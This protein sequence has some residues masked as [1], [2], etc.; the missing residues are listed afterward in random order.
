MRL[1][2]CRHTHIYT[3][4]HTH[5]LTHAC[6]LSEVSAF[7][8]APLTVP[9]GPCCTE[10]ARYSMPDTEGTECMEYAQ[11]VVCT[12]YRGTLASAHAACAGYGAAP[13]WRRSRRRHCQAGHAIRC[14]QL[15][16]QICMH[17]HMHTDMRT[18]MCT[19]MCI[20]PCTGTG[21][22]KFIDMCASA[23][24]SIHMPIHVHACAHTC[25]NTCSCTSVH[26]PLPDAVP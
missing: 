6:T 18:D 4:V 2:A 25:Q 1:C 5:V 23:C 10:C 8:A 20:R 16:S 24:M 11:R 26:M 21:A 9:P 12:G 17:R 13:A 19:D 15:A 7:S 3:H 22:G 14:W